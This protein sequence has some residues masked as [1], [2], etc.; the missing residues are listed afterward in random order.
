MLYQSEYKPDNSPLL[1]NLLKY[2]FTQC[3]IHTPYYGLQGPPRPDPCP[4]S[5][6]CFP[7]CISTWPDR[8]LCCF[9]H[10]PSLGP[11]QLLFPLP[12]MLFSCQFTLLSPLLHLGFCTNKGFLWTSHLKCYP[13]IITLALFTI[14]A[15]CFFLYACGGYNY[16]S[17]GTW[18]TC[19]FTYPQHLAPGMKQRGH[20]SRY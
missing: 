12:G 3:K 20:L 14:W 2:S 5:Q 17:V 6:T 18:F 15:I 13:S 11:T 9:L 7:S 8:L 4:P 10:L 19:S 1:K 16:P